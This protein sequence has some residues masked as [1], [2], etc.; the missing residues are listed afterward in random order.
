MRV[1]PVSKI[2]EMKKGLKGK[3]TEFS[4]ELRENV[5]TLSF[6][7]SYTIAGLNIKAPQHGTPSNACPKP[8]GT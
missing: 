8:V 6:H 4:S 5:L 1:F 2:V 3:N 7:Q